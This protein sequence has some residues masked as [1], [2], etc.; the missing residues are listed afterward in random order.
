MQVKRFVGANMRLALKQ[1]REAMGPDAIILSNKRV[2]EGVEILTA[3]APDATNDTPLSDNPF[4]D[5][6]AAQPSAVKAVPSNLERELEKM[7]SNARQRADELAR[8]FSKPATTALAEKRAQETAMVAEDRVTLAASAAAPAEFRAAAKPAPSSLSLSSSPTPSP[9]V[10]PI[11][12]LAAMRNEIGSLREELAQQLSSMAWQQ[13]R[14]DNP[15]QASLLRRLKRLGL[16]NSTARQLLASNGQYDEKPGWQALMRQL[17]DSIPHVSGDMVDGGGC[18]AFV[19]PTGSGKSTTIGKL[20]ARYVLKH[21]AEHV[22]LVTTDT[23]RIA[24]YEQLRTFGR[25]LKIPLSVVDKNNPLDQVLYALRRKR[26]VLIDTAGLHRSDP[27]LKQ[28]LQSLS[29]QGNKLKTLLVLPA[30]VQG[31][32]MQALYHDYKVDNLAGSVL[33]KLDE[34]ASLGEALSIVV[35]HKLPVAY[36]SNGQ[37]IPDHLHLPDPSKL[38]SEAIKLAKDAV[39]DDETLADSLLADSNAFDRISA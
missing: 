15:A 6:V 32:M 23:Y 3:L 20:A 19:G 2:P 36:T 14:Q 26:L 21:G 24:A 7:Q 30:T 9:S 13:F 4:A 25:I 18:F 1:V 22:A 16:D 31:R 38:L 17:R 33:T 5:A 27:R 28:Q 39:V 29:E 35:A 12:E 8:R 10:V 11:A 37:D 34:T